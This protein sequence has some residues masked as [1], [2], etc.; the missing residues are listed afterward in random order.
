MRKIFCLVFLISATA[1]SAGVAT[2]LTQAQST[3][4]N[5]TASD[6]G[7]AG[8]T[9]DGTAGVLYDFGALDA[10]EGKAVDG[11]TVEFIF[12]FSDN[13]ASIALGAT[14]GWSP[15]SERIVLK[16][17]QWNNTGKFGVTA[18]GV[19][20]STMATDSVFNADTHVVFRRNASG[21]LDLFLNGAFVETDPN[22]SNWRMDG[23]I[24]YIGSNFDGTGDLAAGVM[25]GVA[26]Y[27]SALS[28]GD[29]ASLYTAYTAV[30]EVSYFPLIAI[31]GLCVVC[32]RRR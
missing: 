8:W 20:D 4:G 7:G 28:D 19:L 22:K 25:Y 27:D 24:G 12:N 31:T 13:R 14:T 10:L 21:A 15:G 2:W 5:V 23:G 29:I 32:F 16:L 18:P 17:E 11:S 6:N 9:F 30:P 26:S 1:A 3:T